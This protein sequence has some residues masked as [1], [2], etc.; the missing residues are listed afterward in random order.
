MFGPK[1]KLVDKNEKFEKVKLVKP[2]ISFNRADIK[3]EGDFELLEIEYKSQTRYVAFH[4]EADYCY[5]SVYMMDISK[6]VFDK[7]IG[8]ISKNF[9]VRRFYLLQSLNGNKYL[10]KTIH[11]LLELPETQEEFDSR[12]SSKTRYSRRKKMRLLKED[13][14]FEFRHFKKHE[15]TEEIFERFLELKRVDYETAYKNS[16]ASDMLSDFIHITDV[17]TIIINN[18]IE[19]FFMYSIID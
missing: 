9:K 19:A 7:I 12:F 3:F 1:I 10:N 8:F 6:R 13:Y 11:S 16:T 17:F 18:R 15:L 14:N 2:H 4:L 5:L